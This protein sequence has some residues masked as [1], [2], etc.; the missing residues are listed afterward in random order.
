MA[1]RPLCRKPLPRLQSSCGLGVWSDYGKG[2]SVDLSWAAAMGCRSN[3][4]V[5]LLSPLQRVDQEA[6]VQEGQRQPQNP[7]PQHAWISSAQ[8]HAREGWAVEC[9]RGGEVRDPES[10]KRRR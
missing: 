5:S 9:A 8:A 1:R 3:R 2:R 10:S 4:G 6:G 7:E